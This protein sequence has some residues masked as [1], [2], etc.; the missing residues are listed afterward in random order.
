MTSAVLF[1]LY[2]TLVT[3][4]G[5]RPTRAASLAAVLGLEQ[6]A[7]RREWKARRPA[8]CGQM[9]FAE[10]LTEISQTLSGEADPVAVQSICRQRIREKAVVYAKVH[11]KRRNA[12][13]DA[14]RSWGPSGGREQRFPG[15][16]RRVAGLVTGA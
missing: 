11:G 5:I 7:Y 15:G 4:S 9:S 1:D 12:R 14:G 8:V 2:E 10:A 16:F 3:E 13:H 6:D